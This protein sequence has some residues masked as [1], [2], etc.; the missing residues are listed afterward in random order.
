MINMILPVFMTA[1]TYC[2]YC[3]YW[4]PRRTI[5]YKFFYVF[6]I[7]SLG[8]I[9]GSKTC[10]DVTWTQCYETQQRMVLQKYWLKMQ[11]FGRPPSLESK[12]VQNWYKEKTCRQYCRNWY[13]KMWSACTHFY[14]FSPWLWQRDKNVGFL[15]STFWTLYTVGELLYCM[16]TYGH[17]VL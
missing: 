11:C 13:D 15:K 10:T 8:Q 16:Y 5:C 4:T 6:F 14:A 1:C 2:T 9:T 3:T 7:Y 12:C 17:C